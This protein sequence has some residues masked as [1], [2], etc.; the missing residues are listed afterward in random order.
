MIDHRDFP[1]LSYGKDSIIEA[2]VAIA[3]SID[4]F[5]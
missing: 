2:F 5:P 3:L 4:P 1:I